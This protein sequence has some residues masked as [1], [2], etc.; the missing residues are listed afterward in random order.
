M[1]E[2]K[3]SIGKVT[4]SASASSALA[5]LIAYLIAHFTG[6]DLPVEVQGALVIVIG[7]AGAMLGGWLV[8]PG[9]GKRRINE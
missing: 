8:K 7:W 2:N 6:I 1:S 4:T 5:L 9:D 3:R